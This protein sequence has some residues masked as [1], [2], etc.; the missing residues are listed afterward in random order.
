MAQLQLEPRVWR[1][2]LAAFVLVSGR[3]GVAFSI[4]S[5]KRFVM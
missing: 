2:E 5:I 1:E 4:G 3:V